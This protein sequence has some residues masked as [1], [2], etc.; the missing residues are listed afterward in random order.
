M[1]FYL[2]GTKVMSLGQGNSGGNHLYEYSFGL[3]NVDSELYTFMFTSSILY[4][5][6][7]AIFNYLKSCDGSGINTGIQI[8]GDTNP[9]LF[10]GFRGT[11]DN[12][13]TTYRDGA[14]GPTFEEMPY[15]TINDISIRVVF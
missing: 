4:D 2:N 10:E 13:I 6:V 5:S 11:I 12:F 9:S 7:E 8:Y 15:K 14:T 1:S 3:Y